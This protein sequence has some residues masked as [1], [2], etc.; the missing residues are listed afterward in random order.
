MKKLVFGLIATVM[1]SNLSF[2]QNVSSKNKIATSVKL[3]AKYHAV[4]TFLESDSRYRKGMSADEFVKGELKGVEDEKL[5]EIFTPYLQT[6]YSF[7]TED[8][9]P[10]M[11]YDKIDGEAFTKV[12]NDLRVYQ[13]E[14]GG[15]A[16]QMR[17]R[18]LNAIRKFIDWVDDTF[19]ESIDP[20]KAPTPE[21]P[22][23]KG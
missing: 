12:V 8:L 15:G 6:I 2:G 4:I 7:H 10:D 18:W 11:V 5:I 17:I 19:G 20:P 23:T 21:A 9:T 3:S 16:T 1:L 14:N 13:E 22:A